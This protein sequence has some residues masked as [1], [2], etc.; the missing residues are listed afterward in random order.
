MEASGSGLG[1]D[2]E[3]IEVDISFLLS[4]VEERAMGFHT[5]RPILTGIRLIVVRMELQ[6][7]PAMRALALSSG[8]TALV[9]ISDVV[10]RVPLGTLLCLVEVEMPLATEVLPV[11]S[12]HTRRAIVFRLVK[13]TP[14]RLI[15]EQVEV[16]IHAILV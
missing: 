2:L 9:I 11:V 8:R 14:N 13:R 16:H 6:F 5:A 3:A 4:S 12:V 15:M 7:L 10:F 1:Y